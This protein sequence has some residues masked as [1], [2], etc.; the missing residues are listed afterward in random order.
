MRAWNC[1]PAAKAADAVSTIWPPTEI[2][3]VSQDAMMRCR[4]G[5]RAAT[6]WYCPPAVGYME[7]ISAREQATAIEQMKEIMLRYTMNEFW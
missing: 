1:R 3:P 2:Q 6:Q 4:E 7:A 5:A